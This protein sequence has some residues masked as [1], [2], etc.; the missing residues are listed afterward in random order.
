MNFP[1]GNLA[2][3]GNM[4]L[5]LLQF[6]FHAPSEHAMDGLRYAMEVHLVHKNKSSGAGQGQAYGVRLL[7]FGQAL[8]ALPTF[9]DK[10]QS[11]RPHVLG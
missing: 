11:G 5:E 2:F 9:P 1:P 7:P 4:E 10:A 3:I 6:H 8:H